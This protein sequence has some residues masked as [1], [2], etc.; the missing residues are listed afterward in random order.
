MVLEVSEVEHAVFGITSH[1]SPD[2]LHKAQQSSL[3][4]SE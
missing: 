1:L 2:L 3:P 4:E